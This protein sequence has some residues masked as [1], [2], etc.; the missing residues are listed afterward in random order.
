[1]SLTDYVIVVFIV[2][3]LAWAIYDELVTPR[4]KGPTRLK[5]FLQRRNKLDSLIFVGLTGILIWQNVNN[6]GPQATTLLLMVLASL[7]I[8]LF[9]IRLP[10]LLF[11]SGGFYYATLFIP[12]SRIKNMN[13]SEDGILVIELESRRL[14]IHVRKLDD[15]ENIYQFMVQQQ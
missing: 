10:K 13:L 14:L 15:L 8:Y 2:L 9:W 7:S 11:K 12:Y 3:L 4:L 6:Q 5:V 1:M